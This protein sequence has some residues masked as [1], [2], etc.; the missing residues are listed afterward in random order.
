MCICVLTCARAQESAC[1]S[2]RVFVLGRECL[3]VCM[4]G[5][6]TSEHMYACTSVIWACG[7][8][9]MSVYKYVPVC[10]HVY[11]YGE[12]MQVRLFKCLHGNA[13]ISGRVG[14]CV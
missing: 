5:M 6:C 12:Y 9:P 4:C 2:A 3:H 10:V 13:K 11:M 14:L 8:V 1:V 7:N